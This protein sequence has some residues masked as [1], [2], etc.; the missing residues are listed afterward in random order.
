MANRLKLNEMD[1]VLEYAENHIREQNFDGAVVVLHAAMKQ[2]VATLKG[3]DMNEDPEPDVV[4]YT[5]KDCMRSIDVIKEV[6]AKTLDVTVED[7]DGRGRNTGCESSSTLCNLVC[8]QRRLQG[9]EEVGRIF[10]RNHSNIVTNTSTK[11]E[12]FLQ[13]DPEMAAK[14]NLVGKNIHAQN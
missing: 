11:I 8:A 14:I 9:V 10:N 7:I 5:A 2:L 12:N 13:C 1:K 6:C 4:I 3:E